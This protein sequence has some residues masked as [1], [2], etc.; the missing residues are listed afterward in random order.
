M[1]VGE[2]RRRRQ[3]PASATGAMRRCPA[4][5]R[6]ATAAANLRINTVS[7]DAQVRARDAVSIRAG[8]RLR[9][10]RRQRAA[11]RDVPRHH[12]R[13]ATSTSRASW[14]R[15][16]SSGPRRSAA[17][18]ASGWPGRD[19]RRA[20]PLH[21][22]PQRPRSPDRGTP[23]SAPARRRQRRSAVHLLV[24]VRRPRRPPT[25]AHR[26]RTTDGS[27]RPR[28]AR[29][30]AGPARPRA[31][32]APVSRPSS[33]RSS[34]RSS[35]AR[36]T[37]RRRRA[38]LAG[39]TDR[40]LMSSPRSSASWPRGTLSPRRRRRSST[41]SAARRPR[42]GRRGA[43]RGRN[44]R[45]RAA[46]SASRSARRDARV[47]DLR[48]PLG[49]ASMAARMVPGIPERYATLITE[50]V[51]SNTAGTIVDAEDESGDGVLITL[52]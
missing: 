31:P 50:A 9:R 39:G 45:P 36:S 21:R 48:V 24:D 27:A 42:R 18:S 1:R 15:R 51:E 28:R 4:T 12:G 19:V 38:R 34:R 32:I 30:A 11:A 33:W 22:Y 26:R 43:R 20:R 52:E 7:G 17:T 16:A 35:A 5:C 41:P 44:A 10:P 3:R 13:A 6:S 8:D 40:C 46:A 37:S 49:L 47:V 29:I 25:A 2:R 14:P 23:R